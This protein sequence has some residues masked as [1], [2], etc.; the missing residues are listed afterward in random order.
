[1]VDE[2]LV[3]AA[4]AAVQQAEISINQVLLAARAD[5]M[6]AATLAVLLMAVAQVAR[7]L[8]LLT[9]VE[10]LGLQVMP[11]VA[12]AQEITELIVAKIQVG[13]IQAVVAEAALSVK[14]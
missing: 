6:L 9:A 11:Q 2:Q 3:Q 5:L 13:V 10:M 1:V 8:Q 4:V 14:P 12:V 7:L